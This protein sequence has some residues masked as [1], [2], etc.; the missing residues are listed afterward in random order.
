MIKVQFEI[1]LKAL[2]KAFV[3]IDQDIPSDETI[4][5]KMGTDPIVLNAKDFGEDGSNM[6]LG[7]SLFAIGI[8]FQ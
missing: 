3:L 1:P 5:E 7:L 2:R 6:E 4:L 8:K